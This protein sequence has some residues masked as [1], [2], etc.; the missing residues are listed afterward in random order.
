MMIFLHD[1]EKINRMK[2]TL[3]TFHF[4]TLFLFT[5]YVQKNIELFIQLSTN[6]KVATG[7]SERM[8][9]E[10]QCENAFMSYDDDADN[11]IYQT[12]CEK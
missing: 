6:C 7:E 10:F 1:F 5:R 9:I 3:F 2:F 11:N 8:E 12:V 4:A